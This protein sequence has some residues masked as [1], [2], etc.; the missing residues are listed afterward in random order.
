MEKEKRHKEV[1][2]LFR[3]VVA[4]E[5]GTDP[6]LDQPASAAEDGMLLLE[7]ARRDTSHCSPHILRPKMAFWHSAR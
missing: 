7:P 6:A 5:L 4:Q 2:T 3:D 1:H